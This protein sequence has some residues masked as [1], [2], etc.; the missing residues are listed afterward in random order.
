MK[1]NLGN[2]FDFIMI[3]E[4]D[5]QYDLNNV[6]VLQIVR[7]EYDRADLVNMC[8]ILILTCGFSAIA[9]T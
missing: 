6:D 3:F 4:G 7:G 5:K 1:E 9:P 2:V 8:E